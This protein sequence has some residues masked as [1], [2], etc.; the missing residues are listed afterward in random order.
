M[1]SYRP[2]IVLIAHNIRS[3][4]NVGSLFRTA[5]AAGVSKLYLTGYTP[6]PVDEMGRPRKEIAKTSLEWEKSDSISR[7]L[8][9]LSGQ[10][11]FIVALENTPRAIDYKRLRP[12]FPIALVVGNEVMGLSPRL[13]RRADSVI[14]IPMH[15]K[16]ESLNVG[17]AF[18]VAVY[19]IREF[20]L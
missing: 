3:L 19:K 11:F 18:G 4:F 6:A 17:V 14:K 12:R 5:D 8:D 2:E 7:I 9:R 10:G 1:K 16:K 20:H 15:G 13:I